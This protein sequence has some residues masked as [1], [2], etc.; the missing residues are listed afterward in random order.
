MAGT[1]GTY[2]YTDAYSGQSGS[3][4]TFVNGS[5]LERC[6][7][8]CQS[9]VGAVAF[10]V[11]LDLCTCLSTTSL[12]AAQIHP[13]SASNCSATCSAEGTEQGRYASQGI[14]MHDHTLFAASLIDEC[15]SLCCE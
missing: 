10:S 12:L 4:R 2:E 5:S 15:S 11:E 1:N 6:A 13:A 9:A 7:M 3:A 8:H 14:E